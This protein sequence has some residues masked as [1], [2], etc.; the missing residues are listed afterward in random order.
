MTNT[1]IK[2]ILSSIENNCFESRF[3]NSGFSDG[4]ITK[5]GDDIITVTNDDM[6][7]ARKSRLKRYKEVWCNYVG[8]EPFVLKMPRRDLWIFKNQV[9]K[10]PN[11]YRLFGTC[12][13]HHIK[14]WNEIKR[15]IYSVHPSI[16]ILHI[17][18]G[19][20]EE[21]CHKLEEMSDAYL[22]N[23]SHLRGS[24]VISNFRKI[25]D[26]KTIIDPRLLQLMIAASWVYEDYDVYADYVTL[27]DA[28]YSVDVIKA[29]FDEYGY[30]KAAFSDVGDFMIN[31]HAN[32]N[33]IYIKLYMIIDFY[34]TNPMKNTSESL[35][36]WRDYS[37]DTAS[38]IVNK[39]NQFIELTD[40]ED[41]DSDILY[42]FND[43]DKIIPSN[44]SI[45]K[46]KALFDVYNFQMSRGYIIDDIVESGCSVDVI[47]EI[48][49]CQDDVID[50]LVE[51][52]EIF[53]NL[54]TVDDIKAFRLY[55][56]D[57]FEVDFPDGFN[58]EIFIHWYNK[59]RRNENV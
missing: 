30:H 29:Y 52:W 3:M 37:C 11:Y 56:N 6:Y 45:E 48:A 32:E 41:E 58:A 43:I 23:S 10:Y 57:N 7:E 19:F 59:K 33:P 28:M 21:E 49:Q 38:L 18:Y 12:L 51:Y 20:T 35:Y 26:D 44:Y 25:L 46:M 39:Y 5:Y 13:Y 54:P 9:T 42:S 14:E 4:D 34:I 50:T 2:A 47:N 55:R 40:T 15:I 53:T 1:K 22:I 16:D 24:Q 36:Y 17:C 8:I 27:R 31:F